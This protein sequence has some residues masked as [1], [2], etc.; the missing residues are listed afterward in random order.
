MPEP[1]PPDPEA[2][3]AHR[4]VY[5]PY[6]APELTDSFPQNPSVTHRSRDHS[7]AAEPW[8]NQTEFAPDA[9][10]VF[11]TSE[12]PPPHGPHLPALSPSELAEHSVW[13]EPA[14]STRLAGAPDSQAMTWF[15]YSQLQHEQ[16]PP[17]LTWMITGLIVVLAG[18]LAIAG[19]LLNGLGGDALVMMVVLGP[20]IEEILKIAL[21]LWIVEKRPWLFSNAFQILICALAGGVAFAVIENWVYL[22]VSIPDPSP[23]LVAWRW[24]VCVALHVSC[25]AIAACGLIRVR[26]G[27]L[28]RGDH[29]QFNDG[30]SWIVTAIVVHGLYNLMAISLNHW[31]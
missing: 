25:S 8:L 17:L 20:T 21:P 10:D 5:D 24:S 19:A 2:S 7:V 16:T 1:A 14:T 27:M 28:R 18:P 31:F 23:A 12:Y 30:G 9:S 13:D 22:N 4:H 3:D 11:G 26:N 15:R 29:P 6:A